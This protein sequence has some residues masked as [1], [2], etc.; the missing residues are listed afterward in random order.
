M[1][2]RG[3]QQL[4]EALRMLGLRLPPADTPQAQLP[5]DPADFEQRLANPS[6][7]DPAWLRMLRTGKDLVKGTITGGGEQ[8]GRTAENLGAILGAIGPLTAMAK[9]RPRLYRAAADDVI[10][11]TASFSPDRAV[12]ESYLG[13]DPSAGFGGMLASPSAAKRKLFVAA[14]EIDEDQLLD[15]F[16]NPQAI[17]KLERILG[18]RLRSQDEIVNALNTD[19][20]KIREAGFRWARVE[21]SWPEGAET[22]TYFDDVE[23]DPPKMSIA[24]A[25]K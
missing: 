5:T 15:L 7:M 22:W 18:Y 12:A 10:V 8:P 11:D 6:V 13:N 9:I 23:I 3:S 24:K 14:P 19:A 21:D 16:E 17:K 2:I 25:R 20:D 4:S 1:P